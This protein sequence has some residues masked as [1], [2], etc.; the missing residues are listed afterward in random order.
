[1]HVAVAV[2]LLLALLLAAREHGLE[3]GLVARVKGPGDKLRGG[4][5]V[6][7][8]LVLARLHLLVDKLGKAA[9]DALEER[10]VAG[11]DAA[12]LLEQVHRHGQQPPGDVREPEAQ[13]VDVRFERVLRPRHGDDAGGAGV[14]DPVVNLVHAAAVDDVLARDDGALHLADDGAELLERAVVLRAA[15]EAHLAVGNVEVG[16]LDGPAILADK[17]AAADVLVREGLAE[18]PRGRG[19]GTAEE[20]GDLL[21]EVLV[22]RASLFLEL[23]G[24]K[25]LELDIR[26]AELDAGGSVLALQDRHDRGN[27]LE[28]PLLEEALEEVPELGHA[29]AAALGGVEPAVAPS[30]EL[31]GVALLLL[32]DSLAVVLVAAEEAVAGATDAARGHRS[33]EGSSAEQGGLEQLGRGLHEEF[34]ITRPGELGDAGVKLGGHDDGAPQLRVAVEDDASGGGV[35]PVGVVFEAENDVILVG[36]LVADQGLNL[37]GRVLRGHVLATGRRSDEAGGVDDRQVGAVLVLD[38]DNDILGPEAVVVL[39]AL[40]LS[41]DVPLQIG[42]GHLLLAAVGIILQQEA[43]GLDGRGVVLHVDGDGAAGLGSAADVVELEAHKGLHQRGLAICLMPDDQDG[44][45]VKRLVKLLRHVVELGVR[46]VQPLVAAVEE[47]V[48]GTVEGAVGVVRG[49]PDDRSV[50]GRHRRGSAAV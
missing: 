13:L 29:D 12:L 42:K 18:D 47:P 32:D 41:L 21:E 30:L 31:R 25:V 28:V 50:I 33:E 37:P 10:L 48:G 17:G 43:P 24:V 38:L 1:M 45:G 27:V 49:V 15:K 19:H 2:A 44:R 40:V 11:E 14:V 39:E 7:A 5:Q 26:L 22:E 6:L 23:V 16:E 20:L 4:S 36:H 35:V 34:D 9:A 46:L 3:A 8:A